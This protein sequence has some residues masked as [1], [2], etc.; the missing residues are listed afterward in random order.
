MRRILLMCLCLALLGGTAIAR[1]RFTVV[2]RAVN[3]KTIHEAGMDD[4]FGNLVVFANPVYDAADRAR[5]GRDQ[6]VCIRTVVGQAF[7]C[8]WTMILKDGEI[9]TEGPN[10]DHG[11]SIL[12][13]TGGTGRYMGAKGIVKLHAHNAQQTAWEITYELN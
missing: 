7:E 9:T 12:V 11:D 4:A 5:V 8:F 6:G 1:E 13:V 3:E 10:Y 2:E